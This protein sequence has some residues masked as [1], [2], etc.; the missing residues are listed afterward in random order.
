LPKT[1][2]ALQSTAADNKSLDRSDDIADCGFPIAD[3]K[4]AARSTLT[5]G[6]IFLSCQLNREDQISDLRS[7]D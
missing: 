1:D 4:T 2:E 6:G 5:L 7:A 3:L